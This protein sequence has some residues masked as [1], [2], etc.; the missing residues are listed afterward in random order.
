MRLVDIHCHLEAEEFRGRLDAVLADAR[1]AGVVK[2]VTASVA[3]EDWPVSQALARHYPEVA[4]AWGVHPWYARAHHLEML[5]PLTRAKETGAAAIGEIG[6]DTKV[7]SPPMELQERIFA[8]Q[9]RIAKEVGLPVVLHCR[10]AFNEL[11]LALRRVGAP[12]CGGV[13]HAFSGSVEIAEALIKL[14]I[15]F[16]M[17]GALTCKPSRKRVAVLQRIYPDHFLLETDSPDIPPVQAPEKPNVPANIRYALRGAAAILNV[18]EEMVAEQT[19]ANAW[20]L[21]NFGA[22]RSVEGRT[23]ET[24]E[25]AHGGQ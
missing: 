22:A 12:A 19:T 2:L 20:R 4:F 16:S 8:E 23:G 11:L 1:A 7:E 9:L 6:L 3:P 17:G 18:P 25:Q 24:T 5:E 21:F 13:V 15:R 14:G 10:G